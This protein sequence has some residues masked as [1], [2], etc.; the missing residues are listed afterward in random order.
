MTPIRMA[1]KTYRTWSSPILLELKE[2]EHQLE[3]AHRQA[4][5]N[6]LMERRL[7]DIGSPT[8]IE[9]RGKQ[10]TDSQK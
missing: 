5:Q 9:R 4:L 7:V 2:R 8:D 10:E 1:E 6:I 3:P